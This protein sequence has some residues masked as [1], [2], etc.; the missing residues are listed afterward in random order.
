LDPDGRIVEFGNNKGTD[1]Y[2][3]EYF[4]NQNDCIRC[5]ACLEVCPTGCISVQKVSRCV[6]KS[7]ATEPIPV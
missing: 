5:N 1:S 2:N 7:D 6:T 4:I 3:D